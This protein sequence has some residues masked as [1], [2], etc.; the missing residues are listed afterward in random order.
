MRRSPG[1]AMAVL[2]TAA[3]FGLACAADPGD[4][5]TTSSDAVNSSGSGG[6]ASS[7]GGAN[8]GYGGAS[9]GAVGS[10]SSSSGDNGSGSGSGSGNS[11]SSGGSGGGGGSGA[12]DD[13]G[14]DSS[15]VSSGSGGGPDSDDAPAVPETGPIIPEG[16]ASCITAGCALKVQYQAGTAAS[17][18]TSI[19]P[20]LNVYNE[21]SNAIDLT[22]IRV[23][24][25]FNAD[26][27][28]SL[29]FECF[30]AGYTS[31]ATGV[32]C[33][34]SIGATFVPLGANATP[35]A[36]TYLEISFAAGSLPPGAAV[37]VNSG[38]HD[39]NNYATKFTQ[40]N[41]WSFF[42]YTGSAGYVDAP[43]VTAYVAGT[44][45]WGIEPG[46]IPPRDAGHSAD[47]A[48]KSDASK[49]GEPKDAGGGG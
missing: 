34:G 37:S 36:D 13:G 4:P 10:T 43:Y 35:T 2:A 15:V 45:A 25:Y 40:T 41:D 19:Q 5:L 27:C 26:G 14:D 23:H 28:T 30:Y 47:A 1:R 24:Y 44:L 22:A 12:S 48:S 38:I 31:G 33:P 16:G 3:C 49:S 46:A 6:A 39:A 29:M 9:T 17:P 42:S 21:G 8:G 32:E 7:S 20:N 11:S 18:T